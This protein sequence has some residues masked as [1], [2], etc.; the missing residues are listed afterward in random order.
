VDVIGEV[1][2][3][4]REELGFANVSYLTPLGSIDR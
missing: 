4:L 1:N 3:A 2:D